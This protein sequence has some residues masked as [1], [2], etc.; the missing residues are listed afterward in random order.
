MD[1]CHFYI[2]YINGIV[3]SVHV[4]MCR[5][6]I[7]CQKMLHFAFYVT[8]RLLPYLLII[9]SQKLP[10]YYYLHLDL[11]VLTTLCKNTIFDHIVT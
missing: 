9:L 2:H 5:H 10:K 11:L 4:D 8:F 6:M 3:L 1:K 7:L